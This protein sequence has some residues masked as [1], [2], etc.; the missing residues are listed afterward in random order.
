MPVD[1]PASTLPVLVE[2]SVDVGQFRYIGQ[3]VELVEVGAERLPVLHDQEV[4]DLGDL[5]GQ[6]VK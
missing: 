3:E 6:L 2:H 5:F 1:P 4:E